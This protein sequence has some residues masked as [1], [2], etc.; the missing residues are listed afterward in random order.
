MSIRPWKRGT[1]AQRA[2][3]HV[4]PLGGEIGVETDTGNIVVSDGVKTWAQLTPIGG[5]TSTVSS[6]FGRTGA[7][8]AQSGDYT[9]AQVGADPSGAAATAQSNAIAAAA[10][11]ATSKVAT[12]TARA[13]AAEALLLPLAG[14]TMS[15]AIAMGSHKVTGLT[16]GSSAQDAAAFG[17][18][19][20]ALP[21]SGSA[22]GDLSGNYPSPTVAKINGTALSGLATGILKN[23]TGTGVPSIAVGSDIPNI[24]ESQVTNLT[25]DLALKAPLASPALTGI[26][27]VP[28][29]TALTN[30]TQAASTAYADAAVAVEKSR[31]L[32]AEALA[33]LKT[34]GTMSGPIAMGSNKITGLTN[35]SAASDAAAFGQIPTALPPNGTAGGSLAGTYPNP[36]IAASG[37]AAGSYTNVNATVGTDG[38]ITSISSGS[39]PAT[40]LPP[41]GAAGGDLTGT[42]PNPTLGAAG[43]AGTYGDASHVPAITTDTKGRVTGVTP[44]SIQIAESQVTNLT[45]DLALK[46][47]L[48]SPALTGTPTAPTQSALTNNTDIATTAYADSAVGVEKTRAL[49][50]EALLAPLAAPTFTGHVTVPTP[51]NTGDAATKAYVDAVAAGLSPKPSS[52]AATVGTETFTILA[53]NVTAIA[54]TTIDG[55]SPSVGDRILIKDAPASTGTG[56]AN[57]TQP[58]NGIYTVTVNVTN[59]AFSRATDMSGSNGPAG[60]FTFVDG[61]TTNASAGFVVH[62][63]STNA[64]FTYGTNNIAW[65][66]FSGAGE[67]T[68]GTGLAKSGNTISIENSGVLLASHGGTGLSSLGTGVATFLG[69]PSSANLAAA[70]TD[71]TGSGAAVFATSPVL[72]TPAL[73]TPASGVMTNVTG[74]A[75]SLTAGKAT[76]LVTAR[77]IN[78]VSF[79]GSANIAP[80]LDQIAAPTSPV[81]M[82]LQRLTA[83][84]TPVTGTDAVNKSYVDLLGT[85]YVP[86]AGTP[87]MDLSA[88]GIYLPEAHGAIGN[89]IAND[90]TAV[91]AAINTCPNGCQVYLSRTYNVTTGSIN[92][93]SGVSL[94][95]VGTQTTFITSNSS[96]SILTGTSVSKISA[97]SIAFSGT[98]DAVIAFHFLAASD[99][100]V[101]QCATIT[102]A[103]LFSESTSATYAGVNSGN[104][105]WRINVIDNICLLLGA[106]ASTNAAIQLRYT[107]E[108]S[109]V[110]NITEGYYHGIQYW[111]GDANTNGAITNARLSVGLVISGNHVKN[112]TAGGIWGS[113]GERLTIASNE[114]SGCGDIGID[115]EGTNTATITGNTVEACTNGAIAMFYLNS[116]IIVQGNSCSTTVAGQWLFAIYNSA[117][118]TDNKDITVQGN[119]FIGVGVIAKVGNENADDI[120][121]VGNTLRNTEI[122]FNSNN[123]HL[124]TVEDNTLVFDL[125]AGSAFNAIQVQ[126]T[127]GDGRARVS[128]NIVY[129]DDGVSQPA[130]SRG[131]YVFQDDF[132]SNPVSVVE[133]NTIYSFPIDIEVSANSSNAGISPRF[134]VRENTLGAGVFTRTEGSTHQSTCI[135]SGNRLSTL[136]PFPSTIPTSGKWDV[137]QIIY[138]A[139]PSIS[140]PNAWICTVTGT[141]GTWHVFTD[142]NVN[143]AAYGAVGDGTTDDSAAI[144]AAVA[145]MVNGSLLYFPYGAAGSYRYANTSPANGAAIFLNGLSNIGVRFEPGVELLMDNLSSGGTG[146]GNGHGISGY[147]AGNNWV[148]ENVKIR[149]KNT[150]S[151]RSFGSG[152]QFL[153][154]PSD[155]TPPGGWTA[156]TG[157]INNIKLID[158]ES[159]N[160]PQTGCIFMGCSDPQ[161]VNFKINGTLADGLHFNACRRPKVLGHTAVNPGDDGL[162]FVTYYDASVI[163]Q[164]STGPFNQPSLG[165]WSNFNGTATGLTVSNTIANGLRVAG[166]YN[167]TI[168]DINISDSASGSGI[169]VDSENS[170]NVYQASQGIIITGFVLDTVNQG[171]TVACPQ[172]NNTG[173]A[174]FYTFDVAISDGLVRNA[175]NWSIIVEGDG[176][177]DAIITGVNVRDVKCISGSGGGGNGGVGFNA[178]FDGSLTNVSLDTANSAS[179]S[180]NGPSI[181]GANSTIPYQNLTL[182]NLTCTG[183]ELQMTFLNGVTAGRLKSVNA[184]HL[185]LYMNQCV[186][187]DI[188]SMHIDYP[189]RS[190]SSGQQIALFGKMLHCSI[191]NLAMVTDSNNGGGSG[192]ASIEIGGGDATDV[193][194]VDFRIE[195]ATYV[196]TLNQT[197]NDVVLQGGP[198]QPVDY[199]Y[200]LRYYNGGHASPAWQREDFAWITSQ[201]EEFV[202]AG[203]PAGNVAAAVGSTYQQTDGGTGS[204]FYVKETGT[205]TT[206][207]W[208]A[209]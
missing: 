35:G 94:Q 5:G 58:G 74:T 115:V 26:P 60:A 114:V 147:G 160:A 120:K 16:N 48:A 204:T 117:Q 202:H 145:A 153:G 131:I 187:I 40:S 103:L 183:G 20:T 78:G 9:A 174:I 126:K 10:I 25:S 75:A 135:L 177:A 189:N 194:A 76:V 184:S 178:L 132:N 127:N 54:G 6:V 173:D 209:K 61:G 161:V 89:G 180:L 167:L 21:P 129:S 52:V 157:P 68:A 203:S 133:S 155:S 186:N 12:E 27:T 199:F 67:I 70:L 7:V 29:A 159:W 104:S 154:Y 83:L 99:I 24:S 146:T 13:E 51:T 191:G 79:D 34:G 19:P 97:R 106:V 142:N 119:T 80:R 208:V 100:R 2:T 56:S 162:A 38:R 15:G 18:I 164:S 49:A 72:V 86:Y 181:S 73:G 92:L 175:S 57:S 41:S 176:S 11:D 148:F 138:S 116:G 193:A 124:V 143:V 169:T 53:G 188:D 14:G 130:G 196:N 50:A 17:Q 197:G 166:S 87:T 95:G 207:G 55:V 66:Q 140:K 22:S 88:F 46:A 96:G 168:T 151:S 141:P 205:T 149:W 134:I 111:G 69:T 179:F 172:V 62:T 82:N 36:T 4:V 81:G 28:T 64:A 30:T 123:Y 108:S 102:C 195:K 105:C 165:T 125:A 121:I 3:D 206:S 43:T 93:A 185:G 65:T 37:V 91:Q 77:T 110:N 158:C 39:T 144:A 8:V 109:I 113:M 198:Y 137:G 163:W 63:P 182:D 45:S 150:P 170:S 1:A 32:A 190:N 85:G 33:L 139:T 23:T 98:S 90:T 118:S 152:F 47:P 42:Y 156:T 59:L 171:V 200:R 192:W 44:T 71:E 107:N 136:A 31:A 128:G 201:I 101:E 84:A 122:L 112:S